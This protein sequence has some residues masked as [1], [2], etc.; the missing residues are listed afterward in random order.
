MLTA[1]S[2]K[3][4]I[5]G[6]GGDLAGIA[7][8]ERFK[9]APVRISP[10]GHLPTAKSVI[11][12]AVHTPDGAWE[13]GGEPIHNWGTASVVT[14]INS[15]LERIGFFIAKHLEENGYKSVP[16]PQTAIWR[17]RPFE[18]LNIVFSPDL[19]HIHAGA[20]AGLGEIGYNG[21]LLTPEYGARQR[22]MTIITEAELEPDP[23]YSGPVL[24]D[25]CMECVRHCAPSD[26][27][28]KEVGGLTRVDIGGKTFEYANKNKFRCA[29][30]ERFQIKFDMDIPNKVDEHV[31]VPNL[32]CNR[33][34]YGSSLE[35]CWRYCLPPHMRTTKERRKPNHRK[36]V[37]VQNPEIQAD[38]Y[39]P[40]ERI[41]TMETEKLAFE[42]GIELFG[43]AAVDRFLNAENLPEI[44]K[45][46]LIP[47]PFNEKWGKTGANPLDYL[48]DAK[49]VLVIG[50][51]YPEECSNGIAMSKA[52]SVNNGGTDKPSHLIV[53]GIAFPD[54][55]S[56]SGAIS[57]VESAMKEKLMDALLDISRHLEERG[58]STVGLTYLA[59][60]IS[61]HVCGLGSLDE[62]GNLVTPEF[63]TRQ[64]YTAI[65][66][67]APL[68]ETRTIRKETKK[69]AI[70][71]HTEK[72]LTGKVK[73]LVSGKISGVTGIAPVE[74]F[75][76]LKDELKKV[77]NEADCGVSVTDRNERMGGTDVDAVI[78][79]KTKVFKEP[80]D[81]LSD[82]KSVIV[83]SISYP[84]TIAERAEQPPAEAV[85]PYS[86]FAQHA[87]WRMLDEC[88]FDVVKLLGQYGYKAV[89]TEDLCGSASKVAHTFGEI[90]DARAN[91][92]PAMLAGLCTVGWCG[93]PISREEG[94][95][96]RYFAIVTNAPLDADEPCSTNSYCENCNECVQACPVNAISSAGV[97]LSAGGVT[98]KQGKI[99]TLRCDWSKRY[100]F[101]ADEGPKYMGSRTNIMPPDRITPQAII[102]AM[103]QMDPLQKRIPCIVENCVLKCP[104]ACRK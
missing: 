58:Y 4:Y 7:P 56:S 38:G 64:V 33:E 26:G 78:H 96:Q 35:P 19:S 86:M 72:L 83:F 65:L 88:A 16:I 49:S 2:I 71:F 28:R 1:Q 99:D 103:K 14:A 51:G 98:W 8:V 69:Q 13:L 53:S 10:Q 40:G 41:L 104:H 59:D 12:A 48:A 20:A 5:K 52:V 3:A 82:A 18:D 23:L 36:S 95:C 9:N 57:V 32:A 46:N 29:W 100:G 42:K 101:I 97:S 25:R 68:A 84:Q 67:S 93:T 66:T 87:A 85:G 39:E 45:T 79:K 31:V 102:D 55:Y 6:L 91:A 54:E 17:Y 76:G 70:P 62:A 77:L 37:W 80:Q 15:R 92:H 43:V 61:A 34:G 94:M 24:C 90:I 27:L 89:P 63:G 44:Y 30:A 60:N 50:I 73:A 75:A 21:L 22:M 81:Y 11:V 74:R 47:P